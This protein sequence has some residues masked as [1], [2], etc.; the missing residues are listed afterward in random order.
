MRRILENK[1]LSTV[2]VLS[3][4]FVV[5]IGLTASRRDRVS[6]FEGVVGNVLNPVQKYLYIG[7]QRINNF[8]GFIGNITTIKSENDTL[9]AKNEELEN[10]LI[11]YESIKSE[12]DQLKE[13]LEFKDENKDGMYTYVGASII[14]KGSGNWSDIFIIDKGSNQGVKKYYP[15]V[16]GKGLVGQVIEVGPNWSKVLSIV[17]EKSRVSGVISKTGDQGMIQGISGLSS[18]KNCRMLYLPA[19]ADVQKGDWVVTSDLSKFYPGKVKIGTI[20]EI[21]DDNTEFV[22]SAIIKP[23][24]DFTRLE[25]VFVITNTIDEKYY[26]VEGN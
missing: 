10:K 3:I 17:D 12:N 20:E 18:E 14:G 19:D 26:P 8:F 7:G 15:V 2:I 5:F 4:V 25:K 23:S 13:L 11:D 16:A 21:I 9:K 22:K 1:L 24:V 6:I